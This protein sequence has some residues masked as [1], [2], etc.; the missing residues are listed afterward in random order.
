M[1]NDPAP[2][3]KFDIPEGEPHPKPQGL[4]RVASWDGTLHRIPLESQRRGFPA[5]YDKPQEGTKSKA[6]GFRAGHHV[7]REICILCENIL[8]IAEPHPDG[9]FTVQFGPL[10]QRYTVISEKVV[11]MLIRARRH[12][13]V[14]FEGEML[15]QRRDEEKVI[16]LIAVPAPLERQ[17]TRIYNHFFGEK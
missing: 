11:G 12:K 15:Y 17:A 2:A 4:P 10:F 6:R 16:T 14:T 13:L 3:H 8:K 9:T 7:S 5:G 1:A